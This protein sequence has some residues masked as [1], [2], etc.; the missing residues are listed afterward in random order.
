MFT[1]RPPLSRSVL[2]PATLSAFT[3]FALRSCIVAGSRG[4]PLRISHRSMNISDVK[5]AKSGDVHLAYQ[6]YGAGPDVV[7]IPGL[8]SNVEL[9]WEQ[10]VYR[11]V[12]EHIGRYVHVLE[13]DKRGIGSSDR[14]T[15]HPTLEERIGD[16]TAVMDAEGVE[17][18]S[19]LGLSEGG[20][21]AQLFAAMHPERVDRLALINSALGVAAYPE[22]QA[23]SDDPIYPL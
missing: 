10:E 19:L 9:G 5:F 8:V 12:R 4:Y 2:F 21:M 1:I 20:V 23:Y 11:R 15:Q 18:A 7:L 22:L 16:I 13:F 3:S 14:F 17:R 6:R